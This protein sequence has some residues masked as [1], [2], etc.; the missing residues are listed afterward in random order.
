MTANS[1]S[2]RRTFIASA[3][4]ILTTIGL[5]YLSHGETIQPN[6]PFSSFPEQIG[7]WMG[8][9]Q[10]FDQQIYDALGVDD[11]ILS[12]YHTP[13]GRFV[14]LY[15]GFYQS[16]REGDLIHSPKNCMPGGGWNIIQSSHEELIMPQNIPDKVT[17]IKLIIKK[18]TQR[19]VV[20][21]WFQSRG[22]FIVS[23]YLQKIYLVL[24][25]ISKR[26]T[27]GSFI[28][29]MSPIVNEDEEKSLK[30]LKA[31]SKLLIPILQEYI[32]S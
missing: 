30:D 23:E 31:F 7:E 6:R 19:Q 4:L 21:Y 22:R 18:Q 28:R 15:V 32:P 29:L 11:S 14:Q 20:F 8:K 3:I 12:N 13:D 17:V 9:E 24:D 26:R 25:S 1:M 5:S 27:D 2:F 10:H 16:Q